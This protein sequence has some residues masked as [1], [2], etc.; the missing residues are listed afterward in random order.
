[1][2]KTGFCF[3]FQA[4]TDYFLNIILGKNKTF[5]FFRELSHYLILLY[6]K[7]GLLL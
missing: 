4:I 5:L 6:G 1:M 7:S 2:I 3:L